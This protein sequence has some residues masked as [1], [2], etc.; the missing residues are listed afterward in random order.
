VWPGISVATQED[1]NHLLPVI[2]RIPGRWWISAEPLLG[3]LDLSPWLPQIVGHDRWWPKTTAWGVRLQGVVIGAESGTNA[4][5]C[6]MAWI[7]D[8]VAQCDAAQLPVYVKQAHVDGRLVK[9]PTVL[10]A[11]RDAL[12]WR[13]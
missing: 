13:I 7:K 12:P 6:Q 1:V 11:V 9:M 10:G 8:L 2:H 3:P 4:R 5:P